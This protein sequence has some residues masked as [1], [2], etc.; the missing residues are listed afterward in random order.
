M[1]HAKTRFEGFGLALLGLSLAF[2]LL[3]AGPVQAAVKPTPVASSVTLGAPATAMIGTPVT[4]AVSVAASSAAASA[5]G[6]VTVYDGTASVGTAALTAGKATLRYTP[7][8]AG[9]HHLTATYAG[10]ATVATSSSSASTVTVQLLPATVVVTVPASITLGVSLPVRAVITASAAVTGSVSFYDGA[11]LLGA[12]TVSGNSATLAYA[13]ASAGVHSLKASYAGSSMVAAASSAAYAVTVGQVTPNMVLSATGSTVLQT[14][15]QV[16]LSAIINGA[17]P[18]GVLTFRDG[19]ATLGAVMIAAGKASL[20]AV[21]STPGVHALSVSYSG[22]TNN[23]AATAGPFN[24]TVAPKPAVVALTASSLSITASTAA[25]VTVT[26]KVS[27]PTPTGTITFAINGSAISITGRAT[28]AGTATASFI[29]SKAG[30]YAV[31]AAYSG[32]ANAGPANANGLTVTATASS[33]KGPQTGNGIQ[34]QGGN[35]MYQGV[36]VYYIWY[37][38]WST[39]A[40]KTNL[41]AFAQALGGSSYWHI[42]TTYADA[43]HGNVTDAVTFSGQ[44]TDN[45]SQGKSLD[46]SH[47][48]AIVQSALNAGTLP[49]D[50][51]GVYLVMAGKD[52]NET[53]GLCT[54]Y[55]GWHSSM[56]FKA[57]SSIKFGFIGD[58]EVCRNACG[59]NSN[60]TPPHGDKGV[61]DAVADVVAHELAEAATDPDLNAWLVTNTSSPSD[62]Q[63]VGDLCAWNWVAQSQVTVNG[64][65]VVYNVKLGSSYWL[66]QGL[67]I[68][69]NGGNCVLSN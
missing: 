42:L 51:N 58:P 6:S 10:S 27:S 47:V 1:A 44:V 66:L 15:S 55:C 57:S 31:A 40:V 7:T 43:L 68:D 56:S 62:G 48:A 34:Y 60:P 65:P 33:A 63:E 49:V 20:A 16:I 24:L 23:K 5:A 22:D 12:A 29:A 59:A 13:P 26:A 17:Q 36:N 30:T 35:V 54:K 41:P 18:T 28:S 45:Y 67:W 11:T 4:L 8:T 32:D 2:G 9:A 50:P 14:G 69:A 39:T 64:A 52:I 53:S 61:S 25:T 46:D 19:S 37:G 3:G 21:F 38:D